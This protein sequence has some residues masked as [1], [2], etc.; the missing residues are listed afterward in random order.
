M[1]AEI[2]FYAINVMWIGRKLILFLSLIY[3][4]IN[5]LK[6][7]CMGEFN[8]AHAVLNNINSIYFIISNITYLD[9]TNVL[10]SC[11]F[12]I[13]YEINISQATR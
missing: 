7:I 8:M 2:I 6:Y 1:V 12:R 10:L 3:K 9:L 5:E 11:R 4:T 13:I